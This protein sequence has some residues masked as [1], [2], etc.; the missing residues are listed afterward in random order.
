VI[1]SGR[2]LVRCESERELGVSV[3]VSC[4]SELRAFVVSVSVIVRAS[5][6]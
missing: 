4:D 5:V 1:V 3:S 2:V 6:E